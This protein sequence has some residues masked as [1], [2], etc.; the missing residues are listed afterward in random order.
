MTAPCD[1][2]KPHETSRNLLETYMFDC[3]YSPFTKITYILTFPPTSL[4]QFL[5]ALSQASVLILPQ[6]KLNLQLSHSAFFQVDNEVLMHTHTHTP[7][8]TPISAPLPPHTYHSCKHTQLK[9]CKTSHSP[10]TQLSGFSPK[11]QTPKVFW[12]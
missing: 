4:E 2:Q 3:M 9:T 5:R 6:I 11:L 12:I 7:H 10:T 8:T 1:Y